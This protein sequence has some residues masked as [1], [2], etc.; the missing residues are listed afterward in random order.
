MDINSIDT[1]KEYTFEEVKKELEEAKEV[2]VT[3]KET[4]NSYIAE[5]IKGEVT[6]KYYNSALDSWRKSDDVWVREI[7][8]NWYITK[9]KSERV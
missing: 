5:I 7:F 6:L 8:N 2:I 4:S 9:Q 3:S 1:S